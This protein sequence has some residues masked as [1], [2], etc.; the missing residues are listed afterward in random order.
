MKWLKI[1]IFNYLSVKYL[2]K[3]TRIPHF[4]TNTPLLLLLLLSSPYVK[5]INIP[6]FLSLLLSPQLLLFSFILRYVFSY[7]LF[8]SQFFLINILYEFAFSFLFSASLASTLMQD[9]F[10]FFFCI[11]FVF[12]FIFKFLCS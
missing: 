5:N 3:K 12:Y 2:I 9:F 7:F 6:F 4:T 10:F 11:I 8:S 1:L